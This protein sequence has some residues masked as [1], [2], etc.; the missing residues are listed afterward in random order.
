MKR[1]LTILTAIILILAISLQSE[2]KEKSLI[3]TIDIKKE[4]D[5]TTWIYLHNGLSEAKQLSADAIL[6]HMAD[7]WNLP[8]LC[9]RLFYIV[10]YRY[11][12]LSIITQLQQVL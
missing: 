9:E 10:P 4:I 5:N 1:L 8:I 2:A 6:L 7:Y 3:Y 11:M 12:Y